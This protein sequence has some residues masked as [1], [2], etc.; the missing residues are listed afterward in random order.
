MNPNFPDRL[1]ESGSLKLVAFKAPAGLSA[2]LACIAER[3]HLS[4]SAIIRRLVVAHVERSK[5]AKD[6]P[7]SKT[8][9]ATYDGPASL[10]TV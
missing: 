7:R 3:E 9:M 10:V 5:V 8:R 6:E 1:L 4:V 2:D